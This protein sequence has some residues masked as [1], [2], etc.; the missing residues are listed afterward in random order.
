MNLVSQILAGVTALTLIGVGVL[1]VFFHGD[2]RFHRI[3]LIK[4]EDVRAVRMWAMNVGAYN[5]VFGVGLA[6][7]L[8]MVNSGSTAGGTSIVLFCCAS[9]VFLGF[10]LWVTEKSLL[11]SAIGQAL[12][13]GLAIVFY[14]LLR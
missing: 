1:E 10:W 11:T 13:P 2:Q 6:V 14:L 5:I 8:W 4:P 3:F 12:I 7:G 9:H